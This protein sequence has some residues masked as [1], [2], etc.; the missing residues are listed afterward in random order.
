VSSI[1]RSSEGMMAQNKLAD[2][3]LAAL[4]ASL[5]LQAGAAAVIVGRGFIGCMLA[6]LGL[7]IL[8]A[9]L[10]AAGILTQ[11]RLHTLAITVL[12]LALVVELF[13][14]Y[15]RLR[16]GGLGVVTHAPD[17]A[18]AIS[19]GKYRGVILWQ[20][21]KPV[22]VLAPPRPSLET[23]PSQSKQPLIIP[24]DGVYWFYKYPDRRPPQDSYSARGNPSA[25]TFRSAD[26]IPLQME[27][28][29][30]FINAFDMSCCSRIDVEILNADRYPGTLSIDLILANLSLPG[31][32][33]Q[34]LGVRPVTSTPQPATGDEVLPVPEILSFA[35]PA[36]PKIS[37][38]DSATVRFLRAG[39]RG[40]SSARVAVERFTL[41]PRGR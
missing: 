20:D 31:E 13:I 11:E 1:L 18:T 33:S 24:F 17:R 40:V 36:D 5:F 14:A 34:P 41:I 25:T 30:N 38:F 16:M 21:V 23:G 12:T 37:Q 29:Q 27:A 39:K 19:S 9:R 10:K 6:S 22:P 7:T 35:V 3:I 8:I 2:S 4:L 15:T 32:P 28:R 26:A